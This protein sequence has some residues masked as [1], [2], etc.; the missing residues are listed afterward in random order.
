MQPVFTDALI[1]ET[2][3][4]EAY[5][6]TVENILRDKKSGWKH[7]YYAARGSSHDLQLARA[8]AAVEQEAL[9]EE[10]LGL[11][12]VLYSLESQ[13]ANHELS[14][15]CKQEIA[16]MRTLL[17]TLRREIEYVKETAQKEAKRAEAEKLRVDIIEVRRAFED[18]KEK[19]IRRLNGEIAKNG[20]EISR[21]ARVVGNHDDLAR[22][23]SYQEAVSR[24]S[25]K[26]YLEEERRIWLQ[27]IRNTFKD[28]GD[29]E[30]MRKG[31]TWVEERMKA[32]GM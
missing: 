32:L 23:A 18:V 3:P 8:S 22:Y 1:N 7:D 20:K 11:Q 2:K 26:K 12:K 28:N 21:L 30:H 14:E 25:T 10:N 6:E 13:T 4:N 29:E 27:R 24:I 5:D 19:E 17:D 9:V 15:N 31:V 16:R